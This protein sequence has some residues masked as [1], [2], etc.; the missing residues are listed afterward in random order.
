MGA[1]VAFTCLMHAKSHP[2]YIIVYSLA[3]FG[4][5]IPVMLLMGSRGALVC[6]V[7]S[8]LVQLMFSKAKKIWKVL[9]VILGIGFLYYLYANEYFDLLEHRFE[10]E[11]GTGSNRLL[12]WAMKYYT[13]IYNASL[14]DVVFGIGKDRGIGI[15][16]ILGENNVGFHNDF[17]AFFV[18]Y[19]IIGLAFFVALILRPLRKMKWQSPYRT[20]VIANSAFLILGSMTIEP[21]FIGVYPLYA[22]LFYTLL[23]TKVKSETE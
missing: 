22:F 9:L 10:A 23:L 20:A 5:S 13:F 3:A 12:I 19:G 18:S 16:P 8:V 4:V 11:D 14:G 17:L 7:A 6:V 1:T 21:F 15:T 2:W